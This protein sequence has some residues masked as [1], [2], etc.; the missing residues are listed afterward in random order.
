MPKTNDGAETSKQKRQGRQQCKTTSSKT[1]KPIGACGPSTHMM[2]VRCK[3]WCRV[4]CANF[5][6]S[7]APYQMHTT[8][9]LCAC[10][11][12]VMLLLQTVLQVPG[13]S[14]WWNDVPRY[15]AMH[16]DKNKIIRRMTHFMADE[17]HARSRSCITPLFFSS[18]HHAIS[19]YFDSGAS[20]CSN[21]LSRKR[22]L[23][24]LRHKL[25][26]CD[27]TYIIGRKTPQ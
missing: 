27:E 23:C 5:G 25:T 9:S 13:V 24:Q 4:C 15:P 19:Q 12:R 20:F 14:H 17:L 7:E 21:A 8:N 1:F 6:V 2:L 10:V 18:A 16:L 22:T 11:A 26:S 3:C